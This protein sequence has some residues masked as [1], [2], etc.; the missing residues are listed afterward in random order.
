[1][2]IAYTNKETNKAWPWCKKFE[3]CDFE[4]LAI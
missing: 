4:E 3:D 1:M 2:I